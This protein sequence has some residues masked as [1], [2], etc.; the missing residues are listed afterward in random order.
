MASNVPEAPRGPSGSR[1]PRLTAR[2]RIGHMLFPRLPVTRFLFDQLRSEVRARLTN[3]RNVLLPWRRRRLARLRQRRDVLVNVA[4]GGFVIEGFVNLD[5]YDN[6]DGV[7]GCD[8]RRSIPVGDGGA[9]GIRVEHFVE[10]LEPR[11]EIPAFL[12]D[13][14]R[15]LAPG[16]VLRIIVPDARRF[17]QAYCAGTP[18]ALRALA[19][20][21]PFPDDLPTRMDIIN[22]V[23]RQWHEH[24]W[25]YDFETLAHRLRTAGFTHIEETRYRQSLLTPLAADREEHALASL[26]VDAVR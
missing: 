5:I 4:C 20:P 8:T 24:Y 9:A 16:G 17:L 21:D 15:A 25:A 3:A 14:R 13:C 22:H 26:Y 19:V 2:Q 7:I 6:D 12:K 11:E 18:E 10:H 1:H 23:F